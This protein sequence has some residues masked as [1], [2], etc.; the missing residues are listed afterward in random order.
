MQ[1]ALLKH[2]RRRRW[3]A[4]AAIALTTAGIVL[5]ASAC[6]EQQVSQAYVVT[7]PPLAAILSEVAGTRMEVTTL[8]AAGASP[9]TY[10]PRPSDVVAAEQA[11]CLF[12]AH[13]SIDGW[14]AAL[15]T[16]PLGWW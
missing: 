12:Y 6:Q 9:H 8:L 11:L 7:I 10:E 16:G 3:F 1:A 15:P 2:H 14:A 13:E 4:A 5:H